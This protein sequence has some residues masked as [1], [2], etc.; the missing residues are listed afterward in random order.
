M[1][2]L[3][4]PDLRPTNIVDGRF[5]FQHG[6]IKRI[7]N[8]NP[9]NLIKTFQFQ[10][11]TIK[12]K[13]AQTLLAE[14]RFFNSNMVR[15]KAEK[16]VKKGYATYFQFQ[17][18]TIKRL[19]RKYKELNSKLFQF[20]HGTIKSPIIIT[21]Q[22]THPIFNS[23]MVRLKEYLSRAQAWFIAIFNSNMVRLKVSIAGKK[24]NRKNFQFQHGTI[25]SAS[26]ITGYL[27]PRFF[28]FQHGTIKRTCAPSI[29]CT[30]TFSIP[31]WYD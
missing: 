29:S 12:R 17:H 24:N 11:G 3:K 8:N 30:F 15:L 1:V 20:Q 27:E 19:Y 22:R 31:T 18:G 5:Q 9:F 4:V 25:K 6:T 2:R 23:N 13:R 16:L 21:Q 28:Q 10:H 14:E 7:R 26:F